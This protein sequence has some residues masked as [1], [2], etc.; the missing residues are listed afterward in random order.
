MDEAAAAV[1]SRNTAEDCRATTCL[2]SHAPR[3]CAASCR[4]RNA[5]SRRMWLVSYSTVPG[6]SLEDR[7]KS[8]SSTVLAIIDSHQSGPW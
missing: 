6:Q 2:K 7:S 5:H 3:S 4:R 1:T 8:R